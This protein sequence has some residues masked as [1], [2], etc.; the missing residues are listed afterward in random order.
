[1]NNDSDLDDLCSKKTYITQEHHRRPR[2]LG[3]EDDISNISYVRKKDHFAWHL[4]FGNMNAYQIADWLNHHLIQ[5]KPTNVVVVCKF[6]NGSEVRL[7]GKNNSKNRIKTLKAW[8]RLFG[9]M[10]FKDAIACINNMWLDPSYH[11]YLHFE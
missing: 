3:G 8:M 2:S 9:G 6:I 7:Q 11:L 4:L 1:M 10:P 5:N